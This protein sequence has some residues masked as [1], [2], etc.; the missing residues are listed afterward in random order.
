MCV[1]EEAGVEAGR[2]RADD[3]GVAL[4]GSSVQLVPADAGPE[5]QV[6]LRHLQD[7]SNC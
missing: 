5:Q 1:A 3:W 6:Q 4:R 7:V 2:D